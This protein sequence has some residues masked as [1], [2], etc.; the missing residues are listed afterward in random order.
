MSDHKF[1]PYIVLLKAGDCYGVASG[2]DENPIM[3]LKEA[4]EAAKAWIEL[5]D[6]EYRIVSLEQMFEKVP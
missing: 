1:S 5:D 2:S 3:S 4:R 6:T